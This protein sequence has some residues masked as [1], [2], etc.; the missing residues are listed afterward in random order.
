MDATKALAQRLRRRNSRWRDRKG[1][2]ARSTTSN[3]PAVVAGRDPPTSAPATAAPETEKASLTAD[4][5]KANIETPS[6][7]SDVSPTSQAPPRQVD[8]DNHDPEKVTE[9][10]T[11]ETTTAGYFSLKATDDVPAKD[12]PPCKIT[13]AIPTKDEKEEWGGL[14][15]ERDSKEFDTA[16]SSAAPSLVW[17]R[18]ATIKYD[19]CGLS[20]ARRITATRSGKTAQELVAAIIEHVTFNNVNLGE[21]T[22]QNF[23][24]YTLVVRHLGYASNQRRSR[25]FMVGIDDHEYSDEALQWLFGKFVDD[26]DEIVCV[27]V[28]EKDVR[29]LEADKRQANFQK[30][31]NA[32][33]ERLKAKCGDSKAISIVLEYAVGKLHSTFQR[34]IQLHQPSM[35]IVG[36]RGRTLGG[37]QGL[38]ASRNSFSKYCLQYSPVPVVVVRPDEKRQKKREKR[39][40]DPEKWSYRQMLQANK[41]VHEADGDN[42]TEWQIESK[43]SADEEAGK[44]A[45]ALGL[46]AK[47][48]PTLKRYKPER[49]RSSLSVTTTLGDTTRLISTPVVTPTA[50]A[51]NSE[52]EGSGDEDE[53]G[54]GEFEVASGA[55]LLQEQKKE[56]EEKQLEQEKKE[57]LHEMESLFSN[58]LYV[59][60]TAFKGRT[61]SIRS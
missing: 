58:L 7:G 60:A 33:V 19:L 56:L 8:V 6:P 41:G 32:E 20:D 34:L 3:N 21:P 45:R 49:Q 55:K 59:Q 42:T 5:L 22:K 51:A 47:F 18:F 61:S 1:S 13:F 16:L 30:E 39:D 27:R 44:V 35:L 9:E 57:R 31:A 54:E 4:P 14:M 23:P 43:L 37:F 24:S 15:A 36:T 29:Q 12:A 52:D 17:R 25:T 11:T 53:E 10:P 40:N 2:T 26:G 38:M 50:S 28:V 46:P 48:D